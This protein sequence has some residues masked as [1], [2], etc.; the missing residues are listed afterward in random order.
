MW[1]PLKESPLVYYR[2]YTNFYQ[3]K[4]NLYKPSSHDNLP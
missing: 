3:Q 1:V 4:K 2:G